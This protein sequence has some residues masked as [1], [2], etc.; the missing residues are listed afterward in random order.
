MAKTDKKSKETIVITKRNLYLIIFLIIIAIAVA[1]AVP[2]AIYF[3]EHRRRENPDDPGIS[4]QQ[5]GEDGVFFAILTSERYYPVD[6]SGLDEEDEEYIDNC[7]DAIEEP[8]EES[9]GESED[10]ILKR[11]TSEG[12]AIEGPVSDCISASNGMTT[13][14]IE[15]AREIFGEEEDYQGVVISDSAEFYDLFGFNDSKYDYHFFRRH[16]LVTAVT[17]IDD[18]GS[19]KRVYLASGEND[20]TVIKVDYQGECDYCGE[21]LRIYLIPVE[22]SVELDD[23]DW[24]E[25]NNISTERCLHYNYEEKKPVIYLYPEETTD[26]DVELGAP[27]KVTVSYPKYNDAWR[28]TANPDGSLI[29]RT[30][31]RSLYSLYYEADYTVAHGMHED[32]FVVKGSDSASFLEEKLAQLGLN[33]HEA[34]EFI[35]YW[36]PQ[37]EKSA[38]NYIYFAPVSEIAENMPLNV[39]PAPETVIRINMEFKALDAP[40]EVKTQVLPETPIRQGF[41]LVEW[42]GTIL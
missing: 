4:S 16:K 1:I 24:P 35:I 15:I 37:L 22:V 26:V 41:T 20:S 9:E 25:Y 3:K 18:C 6:C 42:G 33:E 23:I 21:E 2:A 8:E 10:K 28:V 32:G 40:I 12:N 30:T 29:D 17:N 11:N 39:S 13:D 31:G 14:C 34:E 38:Y 5:I 19:V 7:L 36:L 27:E